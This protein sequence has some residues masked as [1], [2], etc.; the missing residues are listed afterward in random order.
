L[1]LGKGMTGS[2]LTTGRAPP[3]KL[4]FPVYAQ[5]AGGDTLADDLGFGSKISIQN[6]DIIVT[7]VVT[8]G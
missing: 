1:E 8:R 5:N 2:V 3:A 7:L 6:V 4:W